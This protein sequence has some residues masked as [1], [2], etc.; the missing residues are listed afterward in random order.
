MRFSLIIPVLGVLLLTV[1][2]N[3]ASFDCTRARGGD[4]Q[5]V[6]ASRALS[7]LDVEMAVRFDMLAGLVAMGTR[8]DMGDAQRAFLASRRRCSSDARCLTL[9]YHTRIA[10]LKSQYEALKQR[11]PF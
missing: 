9:L 5:A 2:A 6:C 8:G 1:P 11:G 4:E 7:E 10:V 3:S